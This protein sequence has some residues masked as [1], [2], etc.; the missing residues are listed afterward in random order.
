MLE[1]SKP[2]IGALVLEKYPVDRFISG[3]KSVILT[4]NMAI[5][6]KIKIPSSNISKDA[7]ILI[8]MVIYFSRL[9]AGGIGFI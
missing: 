6:R 1:I 4:T 8:Y 9:Y 2:I 5:F 7:S 3:I